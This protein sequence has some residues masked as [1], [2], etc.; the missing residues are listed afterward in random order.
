VGCSKFE[1]GEFR[2]ACWALGTVD[3]LPLADGFA[4]GFEGRKIGNGPMQWPPTAGT[5]QRWWSQRWAR[6]PMVVEQG[7]ANFSHYRNFAFRRP[8][9][10][11]Q[12]L[13]ALVGSFCNRLPRVPGTP[14]Q[15]GTFPYFGQRREY[16]VEGDGT[17]QELVHGLHETPVLGY[18]GALSE[19]VPGWSTR[20][21]A[22]GETMDA[23]EALFPSHSPAGC[24]VV[25]FASSSDGSGT[26][27]R[28]AA[29][30]HDIIV[31]SINPNQ[32]VSSVAG[33][34]DGWGGV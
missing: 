14:T 30:N 9:G 24:E 2:G 11:G 29:S 3:D 22:R 5:D 33:Y 18:N 23:N 21:N 27:S 1:A 7:L 17:R 12:S 32:S 34:I 28:K 25:S 15:E 6:E 10:G 4:L 31:P 16:Y 8:S 20:D 26:K 19:I 13:G